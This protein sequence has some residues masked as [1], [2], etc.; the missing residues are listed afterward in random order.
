[1]G[2]SMKLRGLRACS[3]AGAATLVGG[4]IAVVAIGPASADAD[5]YLFVSYN[6]AEPLNIPANG[7]TRT[8]GAEVHATGPYAG[9]TVTFD[10][11]DLAGVATAALP[12]ADQCTTA[13]AKVTCPVPD[14]ADGSTEEFPFPITLMSTGGVATGSVNSFVTY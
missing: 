5:P 11:T 1:M 10:L 7:G 6:G 2:E 14:I 3:L 8:L 4:F 12:A 13:G 9:A